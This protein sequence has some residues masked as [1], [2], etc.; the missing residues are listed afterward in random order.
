MKHLRAIVVI[1]FVLLVIIVAVENYQA[2]ST[3]VRF[4]VNLVFLNYET[5]PMSIYFVV[6]IAF[7]VG[8]IVSG[9]YGI[10]ERF[11]LKRQIKILVREANEKDKELNSLRNLPV[12][13]E[14]VG[15]DQVPKAGETPF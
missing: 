13:T 7:L 12:T 3:A 15:S 11:K 2:M 9:L 4:R 1:L 14:D 5:A 6:V 10:T 8:V